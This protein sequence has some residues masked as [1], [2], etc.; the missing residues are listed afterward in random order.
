MV[1]TSTGVPTSD[2]GALSGALSGA[3][4]L[5]DASKNA[6]DQLGQDLANAGNY[7]QLTDE[8]QPVFINVKMFCLGVQ[9]ETR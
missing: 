3:N 7:Q 2:A 5:G 1:G 6:V 4:S 9:C 8:L